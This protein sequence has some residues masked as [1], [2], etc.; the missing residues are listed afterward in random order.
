MRTLDEL[1]EWCDDLDFP[2]T[3]DNAEHLG[4]LLEAMDL[5]VERSEAYG[6]VW[7]QYGALNNLVRLATK[8]DRLMKVWWHNVTSSKAGH[9]SAI[10]KSNLDDAL[11]AINY[12]IFFVRAARL[13]NFTGAPPDRPV[14]RLVQEGDP[15]YS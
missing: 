15:Y 7:K 1:R 12:D 13:G 9:P 10:H 8:V 4:V 6:Q 2:I 3:D 5:Y 14:L 11:D